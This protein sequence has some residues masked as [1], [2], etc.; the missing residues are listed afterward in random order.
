MC[1]SLSLAATVLAA[2][3]LAR[4]G[5][6]SDIHVAKSGDEATFVKALRYFDEQKVDG[7]VLA[8]GL[9]RD[10]SSTATTT[11]TGISGANFRGATRTRLRR[12]RWASATIAGRPGRSASMSRSR[13][14]G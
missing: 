8:G 14:S 5:V 3:P 2:A 4:F 13:R 10:F 6:M 9:L 7:V 12:K 1:L 11:S